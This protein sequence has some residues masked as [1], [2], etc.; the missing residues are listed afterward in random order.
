MSNVNNDDEFNQD[1]VIMMVK[2]IPTTSPTFTCTNELHN[3]IHKMEWENVIERVK[4][5]QQ[6]RIISNNINDS[7]PQNL[8]LEI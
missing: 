4:Q 6:V 5:K 8:P 7:Q 2:E 3:L 1:N